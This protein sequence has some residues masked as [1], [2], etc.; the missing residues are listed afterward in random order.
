M[1]HFTWS[2]DDTG[3]EDYHVNYGVA[4][5]LEEPVTFINTILK[6][7]A[8]RNIWGTGHHSILKM[9]DE[10]RYLIAYHRFG[11]PL[12]N[13]P[14]GKGWHRETCIAP[15]AFDADGFMMPVVVN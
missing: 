10:D 3:S 13:Y 14:E 6:K 11:T 15:L 8:D 2:C 5:S 4:K 12:E 9:P 7:D 1:Y